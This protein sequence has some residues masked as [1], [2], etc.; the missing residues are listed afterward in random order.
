M[1]GK[2][3]KQI[4]REMKKLMPNLAVMSAKQFKNIYRNEKKK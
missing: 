4:I 1:R 2:K 3:A